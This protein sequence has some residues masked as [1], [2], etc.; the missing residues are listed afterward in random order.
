MDLG[1]TQR[2]GGRNGG[3]GVGVGKSCGTGIKI[4]NERH[5]G[6]ETV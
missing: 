2:D 3:G 4:I 6:P 5:G 1:R